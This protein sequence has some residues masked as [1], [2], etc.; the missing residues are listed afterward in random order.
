MDKFLYKIKRLIPHRLF[1]SLQPAYHYCLNFLAAAYYRFPSERLIVIGVTGTT[2]KTTSTYLIA[3]MLEGAGFKVGF[4]S[5]ALFSDGRDEWLNDKKMTM[6]GR[7]FI[8]KTLAG[9][10]KNGCQYAVVETTSEGVRQFRH[11]FINYD[12]LVFTGLYPE[13]IESHGS[14]DNYKEA[15]GKLFAHL[16]RCGTKYS[17]EKKQVIKTKTDIKKLDLNRV[18]KKIIVNLDDEY[19]DYFLNFWSEEKYGYTQSDMANIQDLKIWHYGEITQ[20]QAGI[21]FKV[22]HHRLSLGV[23]GTFNASNAMNAIGVGLSEKLEYDQIKAGLEQIS[24]VP[25]RLERIDVGQPFLAVVDYA[26][27]PNALARLYET[28]K[29]IPH[30]K[31]IHVLGG[32]GGGRDSSR[33]PLIGK[34]AGELADIVIVTNEDPYDDDPEIIID[35]VLL[36]AEKA[37]KIR[38][39]DLYRI[40]DRREA[41]AKAIS[42]SNEGDVLLITG[43]GSEQAICVANGEKI[44]WDDRM[45]VREE[46]GKNHELRI[47]N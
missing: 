19:S 15:K 41:I 10:A 24:G 21:S 32:T 40:T 13:H 3:K 4:T 12:T 35:Q 37:G 1:T 16:K 23:L 22:D 2:G 14:F 17:D 20:G 5:T 8:Q 11:R 39:Q 33:R 6:P 45:V 9:M 38:D 46:I 29:Q 43:K 27:E 31:I 44:P 36:G 25:G 34:L 47:M 18:K 7:F 28:M 42:L 30:N 26:F